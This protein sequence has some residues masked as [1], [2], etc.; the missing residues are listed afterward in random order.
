M[1]FFQTVIVQAT[2]DVE[3]GRKVRAIKMIAK[4]END[5][6][7]RP[8]VPLPPSL[9]VAPVP[10]FDIGEDTGKPGDTVSVSIEGG[11]HGA[12]NGFHIGGGA[13]G[14]GKFEPTG[15]T[16]GK[17]LHDYLRAQGAITVEPSGKETDHYW[18]IFQFV[19]AQPHR[20]LPEEWW[21]YAL[22]FFSMSQERTI[23][24]IPIPNGTELFTL[25]VKILAS[26]DPGVYELTCEDEHYYTHSRPRRRDFLYTN[27]RQGFTNIETI[28][29]K[30]T[31]V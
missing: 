19:E 14:H 11:C 20:A 23:P 21:E 13:A 7:D 29:G 27:E 10:Y 30:I 18:S 26:T 4:A 5:Q 22:G 3:I 17:Y 24:P 25:H 16:L 1:E 2:N 31:V 12:T 6:P 28:P 8:V 15:V 9:P